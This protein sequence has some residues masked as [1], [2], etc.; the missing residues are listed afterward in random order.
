MRIRYMMKSG[1]QK[2]LARRRSAAGKE[3]SSSGAQTAVDKGLGGLKK[4]DLFE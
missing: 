4:R 1:R 3:R 2:V